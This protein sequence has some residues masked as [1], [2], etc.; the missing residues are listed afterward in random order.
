MSVHKSPRRLLPVAMIVLS[1]I[2]LAQLFKANAQVPATGRVK[3]GTMAGMPT[4][5][6]QTDFTTYTASGTLTVLPDDKKLA[7]AWV[8][9]DVDTCEEIS[10]GEWQVT[11]QPNSGETEIG[12]TTGHLANGDCPD[13][14][15]TF[16]AIFYTWRNYNP[17]IPTDLFKA[18]WNSSDYAE[19]DTT[20]VILIRPI[21]YRQVGPGV[22]V[23]N[24][25]LRFHYRWDSTSGK[26]SDLSQCKVGEY[27]EY[28]TDDQPWPWPSPPYSG[29]SPNNPTI[30]WIPGVMG[31]GTDYHYHNPFRTPYKKNA[32][33]ATQQYRYECRD[34]DTTDFPH[35]DDITI[36]RK[37]RDITGH[38]CWVYTVTKTGYS[39]TV[40]PL[41][42]VSVDDCA[43]KSTSVPETA[44]RAAGAN[45]LGLS[46]ALSQPSTGLNEPIF[47]DL[48][49]SNRNAVDAVGLDLGLNQK[50]N[51]ELSITAPDGAVLTRKLPAE[52]FGASG[53]V[54]LAPAGVFTE[55]LFLNEW[56]GFP[57]TGT[58]RLKLT[59]LDDADAG[60]TADRPSAEFSVQ[61]L[62]RSPAE[63]ERVSRELADKALKAPTLEESMDAASALSYIRDPLAVDSLV[64]LLQPRSL[65]ENYAVDGLGRIG[66]AAAIAALDAAQ[67]HPDGDVRAAARSTLGALQ[68]N[69]QPP[70]AP[71]N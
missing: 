49:V 9:Y 68:R 35:W 40:A 7:W 57:Q 54:T 30:Q 32:F 43:Q 39:A 46:V 48:T 64:R 42:G 8:E 53:E 37:V 27:V 28:P 31:K 56:Y 67:D 71:K 6:Y 59:L 69:A 12:T 15:Y 18:N 19:K 14:T 55:R 1:V 16:G 25:V 23:G 70:S 66:N 20:N 63:L 33:N 47:F 34:L 2:V 50:A 11:I 44:P 36:A 22:Q 3:V 13:N 24:G 65:V 51:L 60:G 26:L 21:S 62:P 38:G 29:T 61:I 41:P 5:G 58:Y 52:G 10:S 17:K 45:E 4:A